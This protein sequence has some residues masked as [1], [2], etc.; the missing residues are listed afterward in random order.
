MQAQALAG[1]GAGVSL[2]VIPPAARSRGV[3]TGVLQCELI[4]CVHK[5]CTPGILADVSADACDGYFDRHHVRVL[6]LCTDVHSG[7]W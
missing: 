4:A 3:E 6:L 7:R 5:V 2:E 1:M